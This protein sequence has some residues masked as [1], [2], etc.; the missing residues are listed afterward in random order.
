LI[1]EFIYTEDMEKYFAEKKAAEVHLNKG[2]N[3]DSGIATLIPDSAVIT[4]GSP[5]TKVEVE[6]MHDILSESRVIK[7]D[8]EASALRWAAE[9]TCE[10]HCNVM[11]NCK[12]G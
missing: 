2:I 6:V 1:D 9:I 8:E 3:S 12:P 10:A 4:K 7:N 11:R 5:D